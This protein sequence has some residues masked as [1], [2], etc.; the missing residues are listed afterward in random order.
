[1]AIDRP[2]ESLLAY[3][4]EW[5]TKIDRGG[6]FQIS[7]VA[8]LL[9]KNLEIKFRQTY[10]P[11]LTQ[12]SLSRSTCQTTKSDIIS[13][14]IDD[15]LIQFHWA[16]LAVDIDNVQDSSELL[17]EIVK[18]WLDIRS[19]S[20]VDTIMETVKSKDKKKSKRKC[21]PSEDYKRPGLR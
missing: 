20:T 9:F 12:P 1:M 4:T 2:E 8:F 6:L 11:V 18:K 17:T 3:T 15:E 13:K 21:K 10:L 19:F 16:L 7:E 14:F 5:M